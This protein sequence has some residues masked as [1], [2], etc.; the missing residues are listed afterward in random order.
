MTASEENFA[1][2]VDWSQTPPGN[3]ETWLHLQTV[4]GLRLASRLPLLE[5][6][7]MRLIVSFTAARG[8]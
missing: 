5:A 6:A 2:N 4:L 7:E 3:V 1:G 8:G